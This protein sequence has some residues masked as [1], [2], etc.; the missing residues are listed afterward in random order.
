MAKDDVRILANLVK[1]MKLEEADPLTPMIDA[2]LI[3]RKTSSRRLQEVTLPIPEKSRPGGRLSPSSIAGCQRQSMFKF[4]GVEAVNRIDPDTEL[5][6]EDGNWRH[7]KW[8]AMFADMQQVLGSKKF[9]LCS[10]EKPVSIPNLYI[11]GRYDALIKIR[12]K[13]YVVDFKGINDF[14]F[15]YV[16][17]EHK[18]KEE[19]VKQVLT[20][21]VARGVRRG[22]LL[23]DNKNN[24]QFKVY[25]VSWDD[26]IWADV[27]R[28]CERVLMHLERKTLPG[29]HHNCS[30]GTF[31]FEKC[32]FAP[33]C[34]GAMKDEPERMRR[35]AFR[36]FKG[37][38]AAWAEGMKA[39]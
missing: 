30:A 31:L 24:Q 32:P 29:R 11:A 20:Y 16:Y 9:R 6:F 3:K 21:C 12:G 10:I 22:L 33:I 35:M 25:Q 23:Y 13:R 8:Q 1:H 14:G 19:H 39:A 28:W 38:D 2:Y 15:S 37:I 7:H 4:L 18:P 36:D 17:R 26:E 27:E 5:I 34:Y